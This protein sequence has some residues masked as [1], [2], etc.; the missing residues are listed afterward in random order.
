MTSLSVFYRYYPNTEDMV[1]S[2]VSEEAFAAL[3]LIS[4]IG[5]NQDTL[6]AE[7]RVVL[8]DFLAAVRTALNVPQN[9]AQDTEVLSILELWQ[10]S[11][12][13]LQECA[14][15]L[16]QHPHACRLFPQF[17]ASMAVA[18]GLPDEHQRLMIGRVQAALRL[19]TKKQGSDA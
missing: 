17:F 12:Q 8:L 19:A 4:A 9:V 15:E 11:A 16:Y 1:L 14:S 13:A 2:D 18:N 6:L 3:A 7:E 10:P 5:R